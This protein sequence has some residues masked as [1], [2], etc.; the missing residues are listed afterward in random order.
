[1]DVNFADL[2][3]TWRMSKKQSGILRYL[4]TLQM[5]EITANVSA[6]QYAR[7]VASPISVLIISRIDM[8]TSSAVITTRFE[9][10]ITLAMTT[11]IVGILTRG[12]SNSMGMLP[13]LSTDVVENKSM[14]KTSDALTSE[15]NASSTTLLGEISVADETTRKKSTNEKQMVNTNGVHSKSVRSGCCFGEMVT[16]SHGVMSGSTTEKVTSKKLFTDETSTFAFDNPRQ[17]ITNDPVA[18][19]HDV[20]VSNRFHRIAMSVASFTV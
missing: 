11:T 19:I 17:N 14:L 4:A 18:K 9:R 10:L 6:T 1:M 2:T 20:T 5:S 12:A 8:V 15:W 16:S 7:C 3:D 13:A